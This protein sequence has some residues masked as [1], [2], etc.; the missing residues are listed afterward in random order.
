MQEW[1]FF[2]LRRH[3]QGDEVHFLAPP[4]PP[5][6]ETT[7]ESALWGGR[8]NEGRARPLLVVQ[9][10]SQ[11]ENPVE[12]VF[13]LCVLFHPFLSHNRKG[14]P[15]RDKNIFQIRH[16]GNGFLRHLHR[17]CNPYSHCR[18]WQVLLNCQ[19]EFWFSLIHNHNRSFALRLAFVLF[20]IESYL[21]LHAKYEYA[22]CNS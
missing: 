1:L 21:H 6:I 4:I 14:C 10:R 18:T 11:E 9:E 8:S 19:Q 12:R 17:R 7:T 3:P 15:R 16:H 22:L 13:L 20:Q 5:L 2:C